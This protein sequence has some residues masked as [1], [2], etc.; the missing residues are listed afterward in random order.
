MVCGPSPHPWPAVRVAG[1]WG[2]VL[3][4]ILP[5]PRRGCKLAPESKGHASDSKSGSGT[6]QLLDLGNVTSS[7]SAFLPF[8]VKRGK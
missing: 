6:S 5:G 1:V 4:P 8:S 3:G 7:L 2:W